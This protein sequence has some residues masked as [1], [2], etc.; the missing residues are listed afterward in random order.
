MTEQEI[1]ICIPKE[2]EVYF[3][4]DNREVITATFLRFLYYPEFDEYICKLQINPDEVKLVRREQVFLDVEEAYNLTDNYGNYRMKNLQA[5]SEAKILYCC[6]PEDK[7]QK[8]DIIEGRCVGFQFINDYLYL[9]VEINNKNPIE[10]IVLDPDYCF[11]TYD[12]AN[13]YKV[14]E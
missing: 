4:D 10:I 12:E 3:V 1:K 9:R 8:H 14:N 11:L 13:K 7:F 6:P 5:L 2:T